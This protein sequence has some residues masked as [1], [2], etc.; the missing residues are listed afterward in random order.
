MSRVA[1]Q[2]PMAAAAARRRHGRMA[3]DERPRDDIE[4]LDYDI[5]ASSIF[6]QVAIIVCCCCIHTSQ[7]HD[8][9]DVY[10]HILYTY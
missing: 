2:V 8:K 5:D 1:L 7:E 9:Q 4:S 10:I 3:A 6:E